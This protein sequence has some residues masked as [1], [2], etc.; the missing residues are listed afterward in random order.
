MYWVG[1]KAGTRVFG[2]RASGDPTSLNTTFLFSGLA[3]CFDL[4]ELTMLGKMFL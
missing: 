4:L 3:N 1:A 2:V